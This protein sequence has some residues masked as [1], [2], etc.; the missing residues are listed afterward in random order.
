[1]VISSSIATSLLF[2]EFDNKTGFNK[3]E[4]ATTEQISEIRVWTLELTY[5]KCL[6]IG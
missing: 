5:N 1:M 2:V 6:K 4:A 3:Q